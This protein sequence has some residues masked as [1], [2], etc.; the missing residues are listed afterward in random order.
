[1]LL[2]SFPSCKLVQM[3][4]NSHAFLQLSRYIRLFLDFYFI[5]YAHIHSLERYKY[6]SSAT[7]IVG[8]F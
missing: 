2:T 7:N 5:L 1:M 4:L 8:N 3:Q 6:S